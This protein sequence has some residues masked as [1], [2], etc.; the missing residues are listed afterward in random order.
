MD[1]SSMILTQA[2]IDAMIKETNDDDDDDDD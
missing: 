1:N 2:F